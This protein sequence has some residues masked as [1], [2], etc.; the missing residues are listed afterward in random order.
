MWN[1]SATLLQVFVSLQALVLNQ[2]P[3]FN[4]AG[5]EK[6]QGAEEAVTSVALYNEKA[7]LLSLRAILT[8]KVIDLRGLV[9]RPQW[10]PLLL[11]LL[12]V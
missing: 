9:R 11:I 10:W 5:Y 12:T 4:E 8:G 7:Y 1:P 6:F 2:N 3:W